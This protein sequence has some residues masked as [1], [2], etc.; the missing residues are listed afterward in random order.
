MIDGLDISDGMLLLDTAATNT[1]TNRMN[2]CVDDTI[3]KCLDDEVLYARTNG[4]MSVFD[5]IGD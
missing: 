5:E 3:R 4:G 1:T 2:A